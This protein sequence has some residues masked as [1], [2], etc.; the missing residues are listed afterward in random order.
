[1]FHKARPNW[2]TQHIPDCRQKMA[3][4]LD[5]K[6][7]EPALPHVPTTP[8]LSAESSHMTRHP[9]LH[10]G[11]QCR[12]GHWLRDEMKVIRHETQAK[13]VHGTFLP[14]CRE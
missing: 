2:I 1:M 11:T 7:L 10:E 6:T 5:R 13:C 8:V 4:L 14:G 3:I 9:P 12:L